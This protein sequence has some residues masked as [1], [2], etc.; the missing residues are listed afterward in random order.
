MN[1]ILPKTIDN[2][3]KGRKIALYFFSLLT[4]VTIVRSLIHMFSPDGG[5]QS[6]ATIPLDT[7][8]AAAASTV[9]LIF[10]LWG[11]SQLLMGVVFAIVAIRYK[12]LIP[13]MYLFIITEY[14][15]RIIL[16][17]LKPIVTTGV[18]PGEIAN[19][20]L[21]PLALVLFF[22]SVYKPRSSS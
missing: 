5:A 15:F 6:I 20:I 9:I 11:L 17:S 7:Y 21:I 13:L 1:S 22:L 16:G 4:V 14:V 12:S 19:L 2:N 18:A 10:A 3:Y 8:S